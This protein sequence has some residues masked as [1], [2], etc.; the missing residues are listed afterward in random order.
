MRQNYTFDLFPYKKLSFV[1]YPWEIKHEI[2]PFISN[3][4]EIVTNLSTNFLRQE[5]DKS[6][7]LFRPQIVQAVVFPILLLLCDYWPL[8]LST[9]FLWCY[10]FPELAYHG[11]TYTWDPHSFQCVNVICLWFLG[12]ILSRKQSEL[13]CIVKRVCV[14]L[15]MIVYLHH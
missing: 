7:L 14:I 4:F 9:N 10:V 3:W 15:C 8:Y 5:I 12:A 13:L 6:R 1:I 2:N 11:W